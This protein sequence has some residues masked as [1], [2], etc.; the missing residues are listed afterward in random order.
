MC[1][2]IYEGIQ[3]VYPYIYIRSVMETH[4]NFLIFKPCYIKVK[5]CK[6]YLIGCL[7]LG[8]MCL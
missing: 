5:K 7:L 3:Y 1:K 8:F 4:I 6:N 2:C